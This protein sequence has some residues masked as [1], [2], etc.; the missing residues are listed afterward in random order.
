MKVIELKDVKKS[1]G[2]NEILHGISLDIEEGSIHGLVGRNGC[3]KT[4]LIKCITGIY[5]Q[6]QG[7]ILICGE[8]VFENPKVK[9]K[10]GYVA[11]SNQ[12]FDG[13]HIDEM[14]EFYKQMYPTFEEKAFKDYNQSIGLDVSKRIRELSKGQAMLNL[15]IHP[16][17]MIMDEPMS[18]LDV[19]AQKQIK[20][21]IVNEVDMNGMSVFISSHDL[22]D[23]E[24]FCDSASM[25]KEGKILYH[26]TM[27][28]MK[29]RFTKLQVVFGEARSEI[30][31]ELPG[32]ITYSNLGSVYTVVL[33]GYGQPIYEVLKQAGAIVV[34]EIPLSLE[35]V[36]VYSNR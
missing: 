14:I 21:F 3:G 32:V 31:K 18:G 27:D 6:D 5:E 28:Q 30:F 9:A 33:E 16:Q 35:E 13:Y 8:E 26:G 7:Q 15:S 1:Y 36:F 24:S 34:E 12:Y 20:D 22:K 11:D 2:K 17:V 25:M 29:E 23:L 19:I 4:T 10:V